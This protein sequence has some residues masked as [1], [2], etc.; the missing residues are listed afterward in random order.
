MER[1]K[2]RIDAQAAGV[3]A[4]DLVQ[5]IFLLLVERSALSVEDAQV[6]LRNSIETRRASWTRNGRRLI[7]PQRFVDAL[8]RSGAAA[9]WK[10]LSSVR[11]DGK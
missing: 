2:V 4:Y 8:L 3:A 6:I 1:Q 10:N 11:L 5:K 9:T 7:R